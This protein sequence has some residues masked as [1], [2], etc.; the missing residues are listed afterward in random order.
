MIYP[1]VYCNEKG[2]VCQATVGEGEINAAATMT[3]LV[4]SAK[5]DLRGT[6]FLFAGIAGVNPRHATLGSVALARYAVQV[7][8]QYEIDARSLPEYQDTDAASSAAEGDKK[9]SQW[10]S[11]YFAYGTDYPLEYP[12]ITYGT[13]VF[14]LNAKLRDMAYSWSSR[15]NLSDAETTR[16]YRQLYRSPTD[17]EE[18]SNEEGEDVNPFAAA[19][20]PPLVVRCDTATSDVYYSGTLLASAFE[21]TTEVWTNGTGVYCMTAQEDNANLEVM[22]RAAI[23]GLVDF[24][25]IMVMRTGSNFDRP[26][27]GMSDWEHLVV[28]HQNGFD[29]AID[30]IYN[31][32][33]AVVRGILNGWECGL[34]D[35]VPPDNYIGDIFGSLGGEPDFG[36]G[37][38]TGG[39]PVAPD[40]GGISRQDEAVLERREMSR[41]VNLGRRGLVKV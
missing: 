12:S 31:A 24:S 28:S 22:V 7:A 8:L 17:E 19:V 3:A 37:S 5:F 16:E 4:L 38:I 23:E 18:E 35:G 32:G 15:S 13:E 20:G 11:G 9:A 34:A 1:R 36:L 2:H 40:G 6:Y 33:I 39:L 25:R 41:R 21:K 29:I 10:P 30:N 26:P 14:E 27:P